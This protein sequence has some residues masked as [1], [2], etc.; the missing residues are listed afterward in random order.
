MD[1]DSVLIESDFLGC[2]LSSLD[3]HLYNVNCLDLGR[4]KVQLYSGGRDRF[5]LQ[6]DTPLQIAAARAS[7]VN[8]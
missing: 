3:G 7:K 1:F 8:F 5:I 2:K 4:A 6:W